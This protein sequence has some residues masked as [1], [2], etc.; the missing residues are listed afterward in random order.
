[1]SYLMENKKKEMKELQDIMKIKKSCVHFNMLNYISK[2]QNATLEE[3]YKYY[4]WW[5]VR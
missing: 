1:M 5:K 4:Q 3:K 2:I